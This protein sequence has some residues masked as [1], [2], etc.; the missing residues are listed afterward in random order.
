MRF[1]YIWNDKEELYKATLETRKGDLRIYDK[2]DRLILRRKSLSKVEIKEIKL[3][4]EKYGLKK[5]T[6]STSPFSFLWFIM[7][8][9]KEIDIKKINRKYFVNTTIQFLIIITS[10]IAQTLGYI[11]LETS[12][13]LIIMATFIV[14]YLNER[15]SNKVNKKLLDDVVGLLEEITKE[16]DDKKETI[17]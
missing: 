8:K 5:F 7:S 11:K 4:I 16:L 2:N 14:L 17:K 1:L 10:L 3:M 12:L 6:K 15:I 13:I 9:P